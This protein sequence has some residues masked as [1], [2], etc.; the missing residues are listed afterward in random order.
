MGSAL[1]VHLRGRDRFGLL[2]AF[3]DYTVLLA[4]YNALMYLFSRVRARALRAVAGVSRARAAAGALG[5]DPRGGAG[6][7]NGGRIRA[8]T[9]FNDV[10]FNSFFNSGW[11]RFYLKWYGDAALRR[12]AVVPAHGRAAARHPDIKA[13]MFAALP[14]GA[15]SCATAIPYA[16]SLRYHLGL[17]TPNVDRLLHRGRRPALPL[18]RRRGGDVRR[19]LH[20][21][22]REHAP[23]T[24]A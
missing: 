12:P 6:L 23:T 7:H 14:P 4:P 3:T 11:K 15:S 5:G 2:K 9:G 8:A 19:D 17:V 18:A 22:R 16:G 13:A 24:S 21:L 10:G 20:P 1:Y